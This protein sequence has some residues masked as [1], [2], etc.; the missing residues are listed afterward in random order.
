MCVKCFEDLN[1]MLLPD[2]QA[3]FCHSLQCALADPMLDIFLC[4]DFHLYAS[5]LPRSCFKHVFAGPLWGA[6]Q[7]RFLSSA[8]L[9]FSFSFFFSCSSATNSEIEGKSEPGMRKQKA[10]KKP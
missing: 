2:F 10:K 8:T 6:S 3:R 1:A 9:I 4:G 5:V 7:R